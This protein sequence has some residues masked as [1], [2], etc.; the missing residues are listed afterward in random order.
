MEW[1]MDVFSSTGFGAAIGFLGN[2]VQRYQEIK[3]IKIQN[4]HEATMLTAR[5]DAQLKLAD[6]DIE[7]TEVQGRMKLL[8]EEAKAFR[9]S[10][11]QA[12]AYG[13]V[14]PF[15][16]IYLVTLSTAITIA[17]WEMV[18]GLQSLPAADMVPLLRIVILQVLALTSLAVGWWF[19]SR[20]S[21]SFNSLMA[22]Y[23]PK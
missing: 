13:W 10:Q 6:K 1:L 11:K 9:E 15:I 5:T 8:L 22:Q 14:R 20:T 18:D 3:L 16:T 17:V 2:I 4:E 7:K 12:N 21:K 23:L 19:G